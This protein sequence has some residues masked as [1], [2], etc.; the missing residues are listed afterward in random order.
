MESLKSR[1]AETAKEVTVWASTAVGAVLGFQEG[2]IVGALAGGLVF[3]V[4]TRAVVK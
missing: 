3:N 2:G 1:S 4:L